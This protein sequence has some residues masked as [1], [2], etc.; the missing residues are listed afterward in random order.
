MTCVVVTAMAALNLVKPLPAPSVM[1]VTTRHD[2]A[3]GARLRAG[4]LVEVAYP[5]ALAPAHAIT[6]RSEAIGRLATS[7]V[8]RGTPLTALDL[9]GAAWANLTPGHAAVPARL[10]DDTIADLL[11]PGQH[12]RLAAVDPRAP[13][14][15]QTLVEDA[16]VLATPPAERAPSA[17][18]A[19]RVVVFDVPASRANLVTSGAVSRYLTVIWGY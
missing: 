5:R 2:L 12:V 7:G 13:T 6:A 9:T 15:A 17:S 18:T 3:A 10:Q 1:L 14:E 4:D 19:G 8:S 11:K 16:V